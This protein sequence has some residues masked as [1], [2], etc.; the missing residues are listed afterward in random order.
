MRKEKL[1]KINDRGRELSFKIKE[2]AAMKLESWLIRVGLLLAGTGA[3]DSD[4][5]A[6]PTDAIQQAG[7]ILLKGGI[8]SLANIDIDKAQPVLDEL[9]GC[10]SYVSDTGIEQKLTPESV[11]HIIEDVRSLFKLQTEAVKLN[12]DFLGIAN[13]SSMEQET[14]SPAQSKPKISVNSRR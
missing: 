6:S 2:M 8:S 3:F 11:D 9:L 14:Q 12:L 1:V 7:Q 5:T 10:C 13:L 4:K